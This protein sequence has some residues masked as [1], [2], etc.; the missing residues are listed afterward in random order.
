[1]S[2]RERVKGGDIW[3]TKRFFTVV[4]HD[5]LRVYCVNPIFW[6]GALSYRLADKKCKNRADFMINNIFCKV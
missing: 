1:M 3:V 6:L 5:R 4:S 2:G